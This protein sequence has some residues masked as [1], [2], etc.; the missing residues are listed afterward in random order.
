MKRL[1]FATLAALFLTAGFNAKAQE[2]V[3]A[4]VDDRGVIALPETPQPAQ[5]YEFDITDMSFADER[6]AITYF[7]DFGTDQAFVRPVLSRGI[8]IL[9]LDVKNHPDRSVEAW[10]DYLTE[11][12][13][14]SRAEVQPADS[15]N[16]AKP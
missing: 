1:L 9:Y 10:N 13:L 11:H 3:H 16:P 4:T 7:R 14:P 6:E 8:A 12:P 15:P 5:S 2:T